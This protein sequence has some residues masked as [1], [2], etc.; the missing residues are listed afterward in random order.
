MSHDPK[1][2]PA[3]LQAAASWNHPREIAGGGDSDHPGSTPEEAPPPGED[4]DE[5]GG[6]PQDVPPAREEPN[7]PGTNPIETPPPPD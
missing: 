6:I 2:L 3:Y 4:T 5:P 7:E 1:H